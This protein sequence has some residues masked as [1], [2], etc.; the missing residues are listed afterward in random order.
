MIERLLENW[1]TK[2]NERGYM[3]PF[4]QLLNSK[5]YKLLYIS[6]H[7]MLEEGKDIIA[8]NPRGK[9]EAFQLKNGDITLA[10]WR[11]IQGEINELVTIPIQHASVS[12]KSK[13]K[14][15]L[16]ANGE[17][18]DPV[19][20]QILT[21][22]RNNWGQ[23]TTKKLEYQDKGALLADF[24][25]YYGKFF[26]VEP[27]DF[28][29]F[30]EVYLTDGA[31]MFPKEKY[32]TIIESI[33]HYNEESLRPTQI[34]SFISAAAVLTS[35]LLN[36]W[37]IKGNYIAEIEAW[38]C[39]WAY[40]F[41][42]VSK[43]NLDKKYW[44][45]S[46][47]II[48]VAIEDS[49]YKLLEETRARNHLIEGDWMSDGLLYK[50]RTTIVLGYLSLYVL[51]KQLKGEPLNQEMIDLIHK[52]CI[53]FEDK[54][55]F[56]GEYSIP[57]WLDYFWFNES[58]KD[59]LGIYGR[60]EAI[61]VGLVNALKYVPPYGY[62]NPY[63][64]FEESIRI[65]NG[66]GMLDKQFDDHFAGNSY[67]LESL[68]EILA[69]RGIKDFLQDQWKKISYTQMSKFIPEGEKEYFKWK[70][71]EGDL[72]SR[73]P[74]QTQSFDQL[75]S[76]S[77][78]FEFEDIPEIMKEHPH[79]LLLFLNVYPHRLNSKSVR[80]IDLLLN[81]RLLIRRIVQILNSTAD[82]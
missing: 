32:A 12:E 47:K 68:T 51:Y 61:L 46:V 5:G 9:P 63:Y 74:N 55:G 1:L 53:K 15:W 57:Y 56:T 67:S 59:N 19:R 45:E 50:P 48:E 22:N 58:R 13:F 81:K 78:L 36:S 82:K 30:L 10:Q 25:K 27:Q 65:I 26:P 18:K 39:L 8:L 23:N 21:L 64:G 38:T 70:S 80:F 52:L 35:Y 7:G 42:L 3:T 14:P 44:D 24:F 29:L 4:C 2:T 73:F 34:A 6:P 43:Y 37:T 33:L 79:F 20:T 31:E 69:R 76:E 71:D 17:V 62:P 16:V 60:L 49:F 41:G 77:F 54:M 72:I 66:G 11:S 28:K 40:I 75:V